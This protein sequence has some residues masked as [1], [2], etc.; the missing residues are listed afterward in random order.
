MWVSPFG[1]N[2]VKA[3]DKNYELELAEEPEDPDPELAELVLDV[4]EFP[5]LDP[6]DGEAVEVDSPLA[7]EDF[8]DLSP[9]P[10]SPFT[11]VGFPLF[12]DLVPGSFS[13]SE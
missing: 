2:G 13:L 10:D 9:W 6:A 7:E 4:P 8:P 11:S 12:S 5:E 1:E 3:R